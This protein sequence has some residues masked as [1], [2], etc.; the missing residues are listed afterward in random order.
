MLQLWQVGPLGSQLQGAAQGATTSRSGRPGDEISTA[1]QEGNVVITQMPVK[2][3]GDAN[4]PQQEKATAARAVYD[5]ATQKLTLTGKVQ[6]TDA[7]SVLWADRVA[8]EQKS[9]D[10]AADG[11]VKASYMLSG[12]GSEPVHVLAARAALKH[13]SG[14]A[15][16]YGSASKPAR[17]WQGASQVE[18]PVLQFEQTEKRLVARGTGQ[19]SAMAVH[20]VLVSG[21][22]AKVGLQKPATQKAQVVRVASRELT[23]SDATHQA[24]F[25]GGVQ[26][27][28]ADG[29]M[30]AQQAT[31]Y[32]QAPAKADAANVGG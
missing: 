27:E 5:G 11:A 19:G 20:T 22:S 28:S 17:L 30:R 18:A 25:T 16:F 6:V 1:V 12:K 26:V 32:L 10:A 14:Q 9:G 8:I 4:A 2:K 29:S 7:G 23:Y 15:I 24:N 21:G 31:V 3:P 13:D